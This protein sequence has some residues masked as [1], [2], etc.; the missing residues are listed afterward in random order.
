MGVAMYGRLMLSGFAGARAEQME[1]ENGD[2]EEYIC[3]PVKRNGCRKNSRGYY[4]EMAIIEKRF[5]NAGA[6]GNTH[7]I[8]LTDPDYY[9]NKGRAE[10][11]KDP[12]YIGNAFVKFVI[13]HQKEAPKSGGATLGD[14]EL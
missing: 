9:K 14:L 11:Y 12:I 13:S 1:N 10:T 7:F 8:V 4:T 2:V 6:R 3:I 5:K